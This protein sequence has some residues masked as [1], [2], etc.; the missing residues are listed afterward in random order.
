[1]LE[2]YKKLISEHSK[3]VFNVG[4]PSSFTVSKR[5]WNRL[6][7]DEI[8]LYCSAVQEDI[9]EIWYE[10]K[11]CALCKA[12]CAILVNTQNLKS[13]DDILDSLNK[14]IRLD[15]SFDDP[16]QTLLTAKKFPA[17]LKCVTLA[18]Q[19]LIECLQLNSKEDIY[20]TTE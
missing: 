11:G 18:W 5:G 6:C 2:L 3:S 19:T 8:V 15:D 17:R 14:F 20:A 12:S 10:C 9:L 13:R 1:M 7:G 16:I 4:K